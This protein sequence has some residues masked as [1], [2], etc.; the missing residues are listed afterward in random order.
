VVPTFLVTEKRQFVSSGVAKGGDPGGDPPLALEEKDVARC[1]ADDAPVGPATMRSM[2]SRPRPAPG[3]FVSSQLRSGDPYEL[4]NGHPVHCLPT[5]QRGSTRNLIGGSALE[6]DPAVT[7]AGVD[8]GVS[9]EPG[10]LRAP[11]VAVGAIDDAPGWATKAP[12]LAVEYADRGQD[13]DELRAKI[14]ELLGAGTRFIWVVRLGGVRQVEVHEAGKPMRVVAADGVLS[15]PGVLANEVPVAV[16]Y[17][18]DAAHEATL[19]NL[20]Q[21]KGYAG[22]ES[23]REESRE[24]GRLDALRDAILDV[25]AARRLDPG[26][27]EAHIRGERDAATLKRWLGRAA[28]VST[29]ADVLRAQ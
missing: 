18:R 10:M 5:G 29:A 20:L 23:V 24:E 21:R 13:E 14:S 7:S 25:L 28:I 2:S 26:A 6:T 4:S 9:T 27:V 12:P 22:L 11:D 17:D 8:L 3:P 1:G 16:L 15:A 19:R